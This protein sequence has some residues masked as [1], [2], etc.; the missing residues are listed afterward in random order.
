MS[1]HDK[2]SYLVVNTALTTFQQWISGLFLF[3]KQDNITYLDL[4]LRRFLSGWNGRWS[5]VILLFHPLLFSI[6][7]A[8]HTTDVFQIVPEADVR[9]KSDVPFRCAQQ[10]LTDRIMIHK[11]QRVVVLVVVSVYVGMRMTGFVLNLMK[12]DT[13]SK[14][15]C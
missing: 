1:G 6:P 11:Q 13:E 12:T 7:F 8:Y 9:E 15:V 2:I 4:S 14:K 5:F 10:V 3:L